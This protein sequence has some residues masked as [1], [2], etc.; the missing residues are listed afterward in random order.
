MNGSTHGMKA[1]FQEVLN[2]VAD[3]NNREFQ[4]FGKYFR[5]NILNFEEIRLELF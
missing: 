2:V 3:N 5:A 4:G 1:L